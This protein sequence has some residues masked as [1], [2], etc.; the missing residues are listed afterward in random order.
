MKRLSVVLLPAVFVLSVVGLAACGEG[1]GPATP[2]PVTE[3]PEFRS[4][5]ELVREIDRALE[6]AA[7]ASALARPSPTPV[8]EAAEFASFR[9][10]AQEIDRALREHDAQFFVDRAVVSE[11]ECTGREQLGMC[12]GEPAGTIFRG[13]WSVGGN[14]GPITIVPVDDYEEYLSHYFDSA[15]PLQ[16]DELGGGNVVLYG[17]GSSAVDGHPRLVVPSQQRGFSAIT[18][19]ILA[20][21]HDHKREVR[22][23]VFTRDDGDWRY[24]GEVRKRVGSED[25]DI[26]VYRAWLFGSV[27]GMYDYWEPWIETTR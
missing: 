20:R 6:A 19:A 5:R 1:G 4:F 13:V 17:V 24:R 11:R 8:P 22:V 26:E 12:A 10:F 7:S 18:S 3:P 16:T 15:T 23:F 21:D 27:P 14:G 9:Q 25:R 2:T